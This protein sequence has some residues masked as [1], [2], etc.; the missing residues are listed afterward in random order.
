MVKNDLSILKLYRK[1]HI[2]C[3][4]AL[5]IINIL[6]GYNDNVAKMR[7]VNMFIGGNV[8]IALPFILVICN[9]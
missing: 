6:I 4:Y 1:F 9:V 8:R 5:V 7:S 2:V 3:L